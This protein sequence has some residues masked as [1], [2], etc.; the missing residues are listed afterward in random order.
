MFQEN[1]AQHT[2]GPVAIAAMKMSAR[3]P[4]HVIAEQVDRPAAQGQCDLEGA[5]AAIVPVEDALFQGPAHP[6]PA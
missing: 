2:I 6:V 3:V 4:V 1:G 5:V